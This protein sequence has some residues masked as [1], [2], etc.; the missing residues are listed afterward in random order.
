MRAIIIIMEKLKQLL[1]NYIENNEVIL[2]AIASN[3]RDREKIAKLR[4]RPISDKDE[5]YYQA[6]SFIGTKVYHK[7][8]AADELA[9]FIA[10]TVSAD[11]RQLEIETQHHS[12]TALISKKGSISI[13]EKARKSELNP[14][15]HHNKQKKVYFAS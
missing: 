13:K 1:D 6:E 2:K 10:D 3:P 4:V 14:T 5:L 15:F 11:F 9:E 7:N 12:A 8:I